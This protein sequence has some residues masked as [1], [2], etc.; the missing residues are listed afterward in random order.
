[1]SEVYS[2]TEGLRAGTHSYVVPHSCVRARV[3]DGDVA[4]ARTV[5]MT[6]AA[7][8][9][10]LALPALWMRGMLR[11]QTLRSKAEEV[12]CDVRRD[13]ESMLA[14]R[15]IEMHAAEVGWKKLGGGKGQLT[16]VGA[17]P[18]NY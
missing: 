10:R 12:D 3:R 9:G 1:M 17:M 6:A 16:P 2:S 15:Q 7:A 14:C 4:L 8:C 11:R 13:G 5:S 18:C